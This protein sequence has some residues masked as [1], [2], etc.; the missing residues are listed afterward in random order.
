[1]KLQLIERIHLDLQVKL[2]LPLRLD[3]Y[4]AEYQ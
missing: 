1:M 4:T 2:V 3:L